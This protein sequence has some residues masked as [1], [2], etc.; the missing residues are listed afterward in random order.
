M[1]VYR[2]EAVVSSNRTLTVEGLPFDAGDKVEVIVRAQ[3]ALP[4]RENPYPL[5][6]KPIR[7]LEPFDSVAENEWTALQ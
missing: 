4:T 3:P 6:G 1:E 5:R 7:Y 2:T